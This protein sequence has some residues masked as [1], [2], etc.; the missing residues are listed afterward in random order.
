[1]SLTD[2]NRVWSNLIIFEFFYLISHVI[3]VFSHKIILRVYSRAT[4]M[5][6]IIT[7]LQK[8]N[9]IYL[10]QVCWRESRLLFD[11]GPLDF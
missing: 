8:R 7:L 1:L 3:L 9:G 11:E 6:N 4:T 5:L 10:L 2:F